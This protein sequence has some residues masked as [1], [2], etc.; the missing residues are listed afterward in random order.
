MNNVYYKTI[1]I[2]IIIIYRYVIFS[3][4]FAI[5]HL[6]YHEKIIRYYKNQLILL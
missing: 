6:D 3:P 1:I 2:Y 5:I 4:R